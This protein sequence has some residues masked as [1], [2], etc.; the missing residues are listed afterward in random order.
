ML[1]YRVEAALAARLSGNVSEALELVMR[2]LQLLP[3]DDWPQ[4]AA[5]NLVMAEL[6]V[7][8]AAAAA[9]R[10]H[11][12]GA[13]ARTGVRRFSALLCSDRCMWQERAPSSPLLSSPLLSSPL[14]SSSLL[15]SLLLSSPLFFS[16]FLF[17]SL[18]SC[19]VLSCPPG[20][21]HQ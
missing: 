8:T 15:S 17:S 18:L 10:T 4:H 5:L 12:T 3:H 1:D 6:L 19:P 11:S 13:G 16:P 7:P 9:T 20:V 14:L 21:I 2:G